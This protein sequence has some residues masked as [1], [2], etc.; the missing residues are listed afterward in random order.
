M[1]WTKEEMKRLGEK[2]LRRL[3]IDDT[4]IQQY[5]DEGKVYIFDD[6]EVIDVAQRPDVAKLMDK[7]ESKGEGVVYAI[8]HEHLRDVGGETYS[9]LIVSPYQ[10]DAAYNVT[11]YGRTIYRAEAYVWNMTREYCS[12]YGMVGVQ[13]YDGMVERVF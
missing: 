6:G 3:A 13:C 11:K 4:Y 2:Y 1:K 12:E 8:T 9:L 5:V 7:I 10:E